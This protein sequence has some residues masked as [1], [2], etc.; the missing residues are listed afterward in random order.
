MKKIDVN[1]IKITEEENKWFEALNSLDRTRDRQINSFMNNQA[2]AH[3]KLWDSICKKYD[4]K[5]HSYYWDGKRKAV[6]E[7]KEEKDYTTGIIMDVVLDAVDKTLRT[8]KAQ[9]EL[10]NYGIDMVR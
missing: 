7:F 3:R 4:L 10:E 9:I 5:G 8:M 6:I 1:E 2:K